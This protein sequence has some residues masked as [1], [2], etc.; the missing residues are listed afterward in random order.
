MCRKIGILVS[1]Y[2]YSL[3]DYVLGKL[4]DWFAVNWL[5]GWLICWL[6]PCLAGWLVDWII[7]WLVDWLSSWLAV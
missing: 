7:D 4:E 3:A 6:V 5:P 1:S 2:V